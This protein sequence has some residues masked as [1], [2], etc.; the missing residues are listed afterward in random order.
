MS[1]PIL[2]I[3]DLS[4]GYGRKGLALDSVSFSVPRHAIVGLLGANGAG[5][6]TLIRSITGLLKINGGQVVNGSV[7]F[8]GRP[9]LGLPAHRRVALGLAQ[10]PEGRMVF[11]RMTVEENLMVGA[12]MLPRSQQNEGLSSIYRFFPRLQERQKQIAGL[13]SGGEQQMLALGRALISRPKL[14]LVD[15]LSLGLAPILVN[16]IYGEL[17]RIAR[18]L[19]TTMLVVEQNAHVALKYVDHIH[20]LDRG[21]IGYSGTAVEAAGSEAMKRAYLGEGQKE[22]AA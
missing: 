3:R 16:E 9:V 19:G 12:A 8:E 13:L 10:S 2:D 15:E 7:T 14:L 6:T 5:K 1:D 11:S 4:V 22:G 18:S 21:S 17:G 20:V